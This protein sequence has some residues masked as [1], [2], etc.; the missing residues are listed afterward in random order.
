MILSSIHKEKT[1]FYAG[2]ALFLLCLIGGIINENLLVL[3]IPF[4]AIALMLFLK[5]YRIPFYLLMFSIPFSLNLGGMS[6]VNIDFPDEGLMLLL[7]A[8]FPFIILSNLKSIQFKSWFQNPL[9]ILLM[10]S[11]LWMCLAVMFSENAA[12]SVKYLLKRIW[13]L[14]PFFF[15]PLILFQER[16]LIIRSFQLMFVMLVIIACIVL[17]RYSAVGF[18]F[19]EVHDPIQPFFLNHVMYG[20]FLSCFIPLSVGALFLSR[21][22]SIQWLMALFGLVIFFIA[23][24][25]SYSRAAWMGVLFASGIFV[26]IRFKLVQWGISLFFILVLTAVLWLSNHNKYLDFKPKFEKTIMHESLE[27]HI[28]ATIQGTDIS[29]AER[30]YRWIASYSYESR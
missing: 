6:S 5:D 3:A 11:F 27:D 2:I 16:K 22:L 10:I 4:V 25:F 29:S 8:L 24:Y 1:Q 7:T 14:V 15:I 12:I 13:Y 23:V 9:S 20:S 21:K 30:Y 19:E 26:L 28:M 17:V 18:R